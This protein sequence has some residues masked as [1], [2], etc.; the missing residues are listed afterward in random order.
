MG[1]VYSAFLLTYTICMTPG[2]WFGDRFGIR[3]ACMVV[4]CGGRVLPL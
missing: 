2:G 3:I 1:F 4:G